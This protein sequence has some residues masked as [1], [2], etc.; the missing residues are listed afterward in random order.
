MAGIDENRN[1]T[2][3]KAESAP[4]SFAQSRDAGRSAAAAPDTVEAII[5]ALND[6]DT[7]QAARKD[8]RAAASAI[9]SRRAWEHLASRFKAAIRADVATISTAPKPGVEAIV[10]AGYGAKAARQALRDLGRL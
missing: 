4:A 9:V 3:K 6:R 2:S 10:A 5:A 8:A 7:P 1:D